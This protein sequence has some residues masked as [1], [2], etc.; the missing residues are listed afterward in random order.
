VTEGSAELRRLAD[1]LL[2]VAEEMEAE[3]RR[4]ASRLVSLSW[5]GLAAEAVRGTLTNRICAL[6]E[7]GERHRAAADALADH[8]WRVERQRVVLSRLADRVEE[9]FP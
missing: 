1:G 2:R 3:R 9:L 8:A 6:A 7:A 4:L 5:R